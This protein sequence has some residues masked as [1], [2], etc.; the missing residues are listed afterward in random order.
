MS[1]KGKEAPA[2]DLIYLGKAIDRDQAAQLREKGVDLS[3]LD[4]A[5]ND[6]WQGGV[7]PITNE[8][9]WNY[10]PESTDLQNPIEVRVD[11]LMPSSRGLFRSRVEYGTGAEARPFRMVM[12]LDSHAALMRAALLRR[13]GYA[14]QSP[15]HYKRVRVR[16][17]TLEDRETFL[18]ELSARTLTALDRWVIEKPETEPV[19][20]VQDVVLEPAR[21]DVSPFHWGALSSA[22]VQGRRAMRALIAPLVLADIPESINLYSWEYGRIVDE[23]IVLTHPY[24][25]AFTE[26]TI[27]DVRWITRWI[28]LLDRPQIKKIVDCGKYP[29]DVSALLVEKI[30]ARR[31]QLMQLSGYA[32]EL[33][34]EWANLKYNIKIDVGAVRNGELKQQYYEGYALRFTYGDPESPLRKEEVGRYLLVEGISYG[35]ERLAKEVNE[36]L[37]FLTAED[38][39]KDYQKKLQQK[40]INHLAN[41][42]NE[43]FKQPVAVWGGPIAGLSTNASRHVVTGTYYG[44]DARVQLVDSLSVGATVGYFMGVAGIP[45]VLP[46]LSGNVT[47]QRNYVHVRPVENVKAALKTNWDRIMVPNFMKQ[48]GGILEDDMEV[49]ASGEIETPPSTEGVSSGVGPKLEKFLNELAVGE[50]F[51]ISDS[52]MIGAKVNVTIPID[53]LL[54]LAPVGFSNGIILGGGTQAAIMRRT[55]FLRTERGFQVYLQRMKSESLSFSFDFNWWMKIFHYGYTVKE[56]HAKTKAFLL[57]SFEGDEKMQRKQ[58]VA[59]RGLFRYNDTELLEEHF[60][61]YRLEHDLKATMD[62]GQFLWWRW[63]SIEEVHRLKVR[64]PA[65]PEKGIKPEEHERT[66]YSHRIG[67]KKGNDYYSFLSD[68]VEGAWQGSGF[69]SATGNNP[70]NSFFGSGNWESVTMEGEVTPGTTL[71]RVG[72]IEHHWG[73]WTLSKKDFFKIINRLERKVKPLGLEYPLVNRDAFNDMKR[74]QMFDIQSTFIIYE[75][76]MRKLEA[77]L[78]TDIETPVV[79]QTLKQMKGAE[80]VDRWC[81]GLYHEGPGDPG[82]Y[83]EKKRRKFRVKGKSDYYYISCVQDWMRSVLRARKEYHKMSPEKKIIALNTIVDLLEKNIPLDRLM[84]WIDRQNLYYEIKVSGFRTKDENGDSEYVSSTIGSFN[85]VS[86]GGVFRDFIA[87]HDLMAHEVYAQYFSEGH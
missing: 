24:A 29:A 34:K 28:A 4:P 54:G 52:I 47:V 82:M 60:E 25:S 68:V 57:P 31:N 33:P 12:S 41:N 78:T 10:P 83:V 32:R 11:S 64:P 74:L 81:A 36:K 2:S 80:E 7:L 38:A 35:I 27:Q 70:A 23:S 37:Q 16:F 71:D 77:A 53:A 18:D 66:L 6:L 21:I 51:T 61:P 8:E 62:E 65:D 13:L 39:A 17:E 87:K 5:P 59:L 73:G 50:I 72:I 3:K 1:L 22:H 55:T 67:R 40:I 76:G 85:Q 9:Q 58:F 30:I 79:Y 86:G 43:P 44:A 26:T 56:G 20:V 46:G 49:S 48:L 14:M 15:K 19:V 75:A 69:S 42:P 45:K 84:N 63:S